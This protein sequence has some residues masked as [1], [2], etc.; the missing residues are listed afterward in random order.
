MQHTGQS[1][2]QFSK[3]TPWLIARAGGVTAL[4]LLT[5]LVCFGMILSSAPNKQSWRLT[6]YLLPWH[7]YLALF[8]L[9]FL[10]LHIVTIAIDPFAK[11]GVI[12]ALIPGLSSYRTVPVAIGTISFFALLLVAVTARFPRVLPNNRWLTVHRVSLYTFVAAWSHG[13]LTGADTPSIRWLYIVTGL[14]V[15]ASV[16]VRYWIV[17]QR[18]RR[19]NVQ[20]RAEQSLQQTPASRSQ[21]HAASARTNIAD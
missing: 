13:A 7:R 18:G 5:V 6:R 1:V 16:F 21:A 10:G 19:T 17:Y 15:A 8:M 9:F 4:V 11:V 2:F 3:M 14:C 12:G 20:R